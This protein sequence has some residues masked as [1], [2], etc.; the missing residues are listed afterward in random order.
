MCISDRATS[1]HQL[2]HDALLELRGHSN[3]NVHDWFQNLWIGVLECRSKT[4]T[5]RNLESHGRGVNHVGLAVR[6]RVLDTHDGIS[7]LRT[8]L[9]ALVECL[10][11][12]GDIL[13]WHVASRGLVLK[14]TA[15]V[16]IFAR[17][18]LRDW[19]DVSNDAGVLTC[20]AR[21]LFV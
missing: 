1:L 14:E 5:R 4:I 16:G 21:L 17:V 11:D 6:E 2:P 15:E 12:S 13:V 19:L 3:F 9:A 10:L 7:C 18:V 20:A 8:L